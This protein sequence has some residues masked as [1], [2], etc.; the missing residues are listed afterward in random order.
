MRPVDSGLDERMSRHEYS[1]S[2]RG[3]A[4]ILSED[5]DGTEQNRRKE[6]PIEA[7]ATVRSM[8]EEFASRIQQGDCVRV[9]VVRVLDAKE[10]G[11]RKMSCSEQNW[12]FV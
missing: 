2:E 11:S 9:V 7:A 5:I 4:I 6:R 10:S 8:L 1:A 3:R 12:T